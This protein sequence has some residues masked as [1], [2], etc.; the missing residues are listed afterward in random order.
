MTKADF[1]LL[2][3]QLLEVDTGTIK[4]QEKLADIPKWDSL[5]VMGF[6]ALLDQHFG[7]IVPAAEIMAAA[8][9]ADLAKLA[10]DKIK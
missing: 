9:V 8:N 10:G 6:I 3:D 4:G 1:Y 5:A 2:L 7:L